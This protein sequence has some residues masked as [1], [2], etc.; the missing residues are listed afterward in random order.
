MSD[1][2]PN[3]LLANV[4]LRLPFDSLLQS[5]RVS[6][7]WRALIDSSDFIK[8]HL[9][10]ANQE[11]NSPSGIKIIGLNQNNF[12]TLVLDLE[13]DSSSITASA[14]Q[15]NGPSDYSGSE[16]CL[17]GSCNGLLCLMY[18]DTDKIILWNPWIQKSWEL[19]SFPIEY[20][21]RG[22]AIFHLGFGYD[23]VDDE[24]KVLNR[25]SF[26]IYVIEINRVGGGFGADIWVMEDYEVDKSWTKLTSVTMP[27]WT[28]WSLTPLALS[29]N[30]RQLL[31]QIDG[32]KLVLHDLE[33]K[34][35]SDLATRGDVSFVQSSC[36]CIGSLVTPFGTD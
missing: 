29:K 33:T 16:V 17:K 5:R 15:L 27:G 23:R 7:S 12:Y 10:K 21:T 32:V 25:T 36:T 31:L 20:H 28:F 8:I 34:R 24:Y 35:I 18:P 30:N 6:K 3:H 22:S 4:L 2:I 11:A 9:N 14:K 26:Q 13:A 19:P 1:Y